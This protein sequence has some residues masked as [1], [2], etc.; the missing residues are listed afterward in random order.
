MSS[1]RNNKVN[2]VEKEK[3]I[4][5]KIEDKLNEVVEPFYRAAVQCP[6][7]CA[8]KWSSFK[9]F[10]YVFF[11]LSLVGYFIGTIWWAIVNRDV[12]K[13]AIADAKVNAYNASVYAWSKFQGTQGQQPAAAAL[14][15]EQAAAAA[16][17]AQAP[18]A[19]GRYSLNDISITSV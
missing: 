7:G 17:A 4:F 3:N 10:L 2:K 14:T 18:L 16:A 8:P 11:I 12:L 6:K 15:P 5:D 19:G 1:N 9:I 13:K